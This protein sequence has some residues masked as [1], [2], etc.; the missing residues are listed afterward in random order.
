MS[1]IWK[2]NIDVV[3]I[4]GPGCLTPKATQAETTSGAHQLK[5]KALV[6]SSVA[7]TSS[8]SIAAVYYEPVVLQGV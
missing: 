6:G 8:A 1:S 2:Y 5:T 4:S 7:H 3:G